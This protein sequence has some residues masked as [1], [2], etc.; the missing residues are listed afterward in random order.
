MRASANVMF[1]FCGRCIA[2]RIRATA[3]VQAMLLMQKAK[4]YLQEAEV[5][6]TF[7]HSVLLCCCGVVA[8]QA[9]FLPMATRTKQRGPAVTQRC[10]VQGVL[11]AIL[12]LAGGAC[13]PKC[14][15]DPA[16]GRGGGA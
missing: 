14:V 4:T 5:C 10:N 8:L 7:P 15:C 13:H 11:R 9:D 12:E 16:D 6:A 1:E 3:V 2:H